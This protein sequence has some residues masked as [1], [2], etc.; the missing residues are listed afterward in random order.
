MRLSSFFSRPVIIKVVSTSLL[1]CTVAAIFTANASAAPPF[2]RGEVLVDFAP[3]ASP[4]ARAEARRSAR[5]A[6]ATP[7]SPTRQKT[8]QKWVLEKGQTVEQVLK[9]LSKNPNIRVAEPNYI[10]TSSSEANDEFYADGS[11]WGMYGDATL[12]NANQYGSQAGEAWSKGFTGSSDVVIGVIDE[13]IDFNHPDL[14]PNIW[15]NPQEIADDGIDNDNN[16]YVDDVHGWDFKNGNNTVFDGVDDHGTH[17]SGTIGAQGNDGYGVAGV[18]WSVKMI[19]GKFLEGG[20]TTQGAIEAVDY[21]AALKQ[22]GVNI[23]ATSN[24]WG[25]GG[26]SQ[27]LS[28]AINA[29]GDLGMLFIAAAGNSNVNNDAGDYYPANYECLGDN[30]NRSWDCVMAVASITS[31]GAKSSF[32][33]YGATRVDIGAPGSSI[34][35][36]VGGSDNYSTYNGTSMA[37]PHVSGAAALC[38]SINPNFS[39]EQIKAAIM[40][41]ATPT[42]SLNG[43]TFSNGRLNVSDMA[44]YC[45]APPPLSGAPS[46]LIASAL[47]DQSIGLEWTDGTSNEWGIQ[48]QIADGNCSEFSNHTTA[49]PDSTSAVISGLDAETTY[50]FRVAAFSFNADGSRTNTL[51]TDDANATTFPPPLPY[52]CQATDYVWR[53]MSNANVLNLADDSS[54]NVVLPDGLNLLFYGN[55]VNEVSISSNGY[56][57]F[58]ATTSNPYQNV[59]IPNTAAPNSYAAPFWDDLIPTVGGTIKH[60]TVGSA[61]NR[62][63]V[64]SWEGIPHYPD[65]G[66]A[67]FQ[68]QIEETS[69]VISFHYQDV[70]FENPTYDR[71]ASATVGLENSDG[72]SG[73]LIS[74]NAGNLENNQAWACQPDDG[75]PPNTAPIAAYSHSADFLSVNFF[76]DSTDPDS[77]D[78]VTAWRWDF[79]DGNESSEQNPSHTYTEAGT[80]IVVLEVSDGTAWSTPVSQSVDVVAPNTAPVANFTFVANGLTVAFTDTS[81]DN[82]LGDAVESW[83]WDFGDGT[84]A[85][86]QNPSHTY[87]A[88]GTYTVTLVVSDGEASSD[89]LDQSVTVA[90][91]PDAVTIL[92]ASYNSSRGELKV[93]ATSTKQPQAVLTLEGFGEMTFKRDRY[94]FKLRGVSPADVPSTAVVNSS[95]GGSASA[96]VEGAPQPTPPGKASAPSPSDNATGV[97]LSPTLTWTSG[98]NTSQSEISFGPAGELGPAVSVSGS[99]YPVG[100]LAENTAYQWRIDERNEYGTTTGDVWQFT[101]GSGQSEDV[102][103]IIKAEWRASRNLLKVEATSDLAP[104]AVLTVKDYG[105]M[106]YQAN[107]NK[108]VFESRSVSANPGSVTVDSSLGGTANLTVRQR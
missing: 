10:L 33:S 36:T 19:S 30:G 70:Y 80:Y 65:V 5:V 69:G 94:E 68:I 44:D 8:A 86:T 13:G 52:I 97:G 38:A 34:K 104:D 56:V 14:A 78:A 103:S 101:T 61:P 73:T 21:M 22:R 4:S 82:D 83:S 96:P 55:P 77:G 79:G 59:T 76:D 11:L 93:R 90:A 40:V 53:D 67:S 2:V 49:H 64:S 41:A 62:T 100:P 91:E 51:P 102:V 60:A 16:G 63:F 42:D 43:I 75:A 1:T 47:S 88:G 92:S 39:G 17:V 74:F 9:Q 12:P 3:G 15:V 54:A 35:S 7:L 27:L 72:S 48:I 28:E 98:S 89:S 45:S 37:T 31:S 46:G 57:H 24:S 106:T 71:G 66:A 95:E 105:V 20:G 58:G 29:A 18:N 99:S 6:T 85:V 50:C 26:R 25:G 81:T 108:Y 87:A 23:V 107:K 32:S 84:T